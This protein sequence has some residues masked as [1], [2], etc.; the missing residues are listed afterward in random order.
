[1]I[2]HKSGLWIGLAAACSIG[3][4]FALDE[5]KDLSAEVGGESSTETRDS[6]KSSDIAL[7]VSNAKT[8][9]FFSSE[10]SSSTRLFYSQPNEA[11]TR[12]A[13]YDTGEWGLDLVTKEHRGMVKSCVPEI[14]RSCGGVVP[15]GIWVDS[16]FELNPLN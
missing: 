16:V 8:Y 10:M 9:E 2:L 4:Y 5:A 12:S 6:S 15:L 3:V 1:M 7:N 13:I 14:Q 11:I